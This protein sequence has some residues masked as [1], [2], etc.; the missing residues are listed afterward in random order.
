MSLRL[1][2]A[3]LI[4][5]SSGC[6]DRAFRLGIVKEQ[7]GTNCRVRVTFREFDQMLSYWLPVVV[8]KTQDDKVFWLP[9]P[10]E[11]VVCLMDEHDEAGV[12]LGAIYS[13]PDRPPVA[14]ANKYHI[15]FKDGT[16]FEYDRGLHVLRA[17]FEDGTAISYDAGTHA[18]TIAGGA[19]TTV[20]ASA[21][22]GISLESGSSQVTIDPSGVAISPPLPISSTVAQ[23]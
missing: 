16:S 17:A 10:G 6:R 7:D 3:P 21:P 19:Q 12:V 1:G 15:G 18:L 20:V 11:Q 22:G 2:P 4:E 23:T 5:R 14:D 13:Q 8:P 9:D